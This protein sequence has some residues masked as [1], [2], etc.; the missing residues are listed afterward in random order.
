[1]T[2]SGPDLSLS[3]TLADDVAVLVVGLTT[4][5]DDPPAVVG[6]DLLPDGVAETIAAQVA[7]VGAK[8]KPEEVTRIPAPAG[9]AVRSVLAVGLGAPDK[10]DAEQV[11]PSP[12]APRRRSLRGADV[13]ASTLGAADLAG[14]AEGSYLGAYEFTEYK[15]EKSAPKPG[16]LPPRAITLLVDAAA[17]GTVEAAATLTRSSPSPRPSRLARNL[18]N[19]PPSDLYPA[20]F[21][22]RAAALAT[23][24]GLSVEMLDEKA[25]DTGG[26]GGILGVGKG[27]SR[28]PRLVR[29]AHS[30]VDGAHEGRAGRQ[31]HHVRHR[32]HLHQARREH[33][34]DDLATCPVPPR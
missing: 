32:R 8:G 27:S 10:V 6:A 21:A 14:A 4:S 19:T 5:D 28:P 25:L 33:G 9:L 13:V 24:A 1:M 11:R 22:D 23:A 18:V 15:S 7:A 29:L 2:T 20:E 34:P 26:Y 31:G 16:D 12:P 17:G 30:G 3:T